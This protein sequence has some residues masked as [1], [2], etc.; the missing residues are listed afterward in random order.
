[1]NQ[2]KGNWA[3][4]SL[5]AISLW[6]T[7]STTRSGV[8]APEVIPTVTGPLGRKEASLVRSS[9]RGFVLNAVVG[10]DSFRG[11]DMKGPDATADRNFL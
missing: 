3:Q 9:P 2:C 1:M 7:C 10:M 5:K 6:M 11:V 8:E 4:F